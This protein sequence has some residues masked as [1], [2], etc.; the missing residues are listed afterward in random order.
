MET[1]TASRK[2]ATENVATKNQHRFQALHEASQ[3]RLQYR[4]TQG[5]IPT[6]ITEFLNRKQTHA[7]PTLHHEELGSDQ[8]LPISRNNPNP[9]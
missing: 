5:R 1:H 4:T 2:P 8:M 6:V 9:V 3:R 7:S